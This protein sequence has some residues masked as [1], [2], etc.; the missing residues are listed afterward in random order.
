MQNQASKRQI[1]NQYINVQ[2]LWSTLVIPFSSTKIFFNANSLN[3]KVAKRR[4]DVVFIK[5]YFKGIFNIHSREL[6]YNIPHFSK[7]MSHRC[8]LPSISNFS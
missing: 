1:F 2:Y 7:H 4:Y 8:S 6:D 5:L 3:V